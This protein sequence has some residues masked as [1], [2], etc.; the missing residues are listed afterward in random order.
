LGQ[1][2]R[3]LG[4]H[5]GDRMVVQAVKP[6]IGIGD[7]LSTSTA[8]AT[9]PFPV[10]PSTNADAKLFNQLQQ[11]PQSLLR[12]P[13]DVITLVEG[14]DGV[15]RGSYGVQKPGHYNFLFGLEGTTKSTGRFSRQ[16]LKT[17]YVRPAPDATATSLQINVQSLPNGGQLAITITPRTKL[18]DKLGPG[19]ANY[20]WFTA[21]GLQPFKAVD[22]LDGTFIAKASYTSILPP[23]VS[24]HFLNVSLVIGDSVT[25]ENLPVPLDDS[26]VFVKSL[27]PPGGFAGSERFFIGFFSHGGVAS[28]ENFPH[29][30]VSPLDSYVYKQGEVR[31]E[32]YLHSTR[33]PE[34]GFI[35]GQR[36]PPHDEETGSG[37]GNLFRLRWNVDDSTGRVSLHT[38]YSVQRGEERKETPTNDGCV[39]IYAACQRGGA[40]RPP[41]VYYIGEP[42]M[43]P[44]VVRQIQQALSQKGVNPGPI[45]GIYGPLTAAAVRAFQTAN[46]LVADGEV[47][48]KTAQALGVQL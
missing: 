44:N 34:E 16:Q 30:F 40:E 2:V 32:Y 27:V 36:N 1:P 29:R 15:Y 4:T 24:I 14:A 8:A 26:T 48:P 10:D 20:F 9:Q 13:S 42:N 37:P 6:G 11:N 47:G 43:D 7:L 33:L 17:V 19:W 46:A 3:A 39:K 22:N 35:Q 41:N 5:A 45:D 23:P 18:G 25:A 12:D 38:S 31:Y 28:V 21:P